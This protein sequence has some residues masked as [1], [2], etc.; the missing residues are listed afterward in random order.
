MNMFIVWSVIAAIGL[1]LLVLS[2]LGSD[3]G[4]DFGLD[5][6]TSGVGVVVGVML[7]ICGAVGIITHSLKAPLWSSVTAIVI[8]VIVAGVITWSLIQFFIRASGDGNE[9]SLKTLVGTDV[10]ATEP[11]DA[12][13][14]AKTK[15]TIGD[16][17]QPLTVYYKTDRKITAGDVLHVVGLSPKSTQEILVEPVPSDVKS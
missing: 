12:N 8:S 15:V 1:V 4:V 13:T 16:P 14:I 3:I 17:P 2:A 7:T 11:A 10:V 9:A 5:G 6:S